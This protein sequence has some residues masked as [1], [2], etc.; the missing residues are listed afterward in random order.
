M[1]AIEFLKEYR[2]MC[3][4]YIHRFGCD[5]CPL[6]DE[7]C[8]GTGVSNKTDGEYLTITSMVEQWNKDHPLVTNE[9]KFREV[10]GDMAVNSMLSLCTD[11]IRE[12]MK[13]EYKERK[14]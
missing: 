13:Q 8:L 2:R 11:D 10:F 6:K 9:M 4:S 7:Q 3:N 14:P 5:G 12:W 1:E